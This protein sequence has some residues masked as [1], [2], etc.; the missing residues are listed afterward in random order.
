METE[1]K[2]KRTLYVGGLDE[3]VSPEILQA[4]FVPFGHITDLQLPLDVKTGAR[5]Q[6]RRGDIHH[7]D[8]FVAKR[9][10]KPIHCADKNKGF[11]FVE[12]ADES[13]AKDALENMNGSEIYGRVVRVTIANPAKSRNKAVWSEAEDWYSNLKG[14]TEAGLDVETAHHE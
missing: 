6:Y 2:A 7:T 13:D 4:A 14:A 3:A 1:N 5:D 8:Y 9:L 10:L 12:F 11:G